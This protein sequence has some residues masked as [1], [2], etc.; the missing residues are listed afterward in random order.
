[1]QGGG[2]GQRCSE[3]LY[4]GRKWPRRGADEGCITETETEDSMGKDQVVQRIIVNLRERKCAW[5][6][7]GKG[8]VGMRQKRV[9]CR[10][11]PYRERV[12]AGIW[13]SSPE[14]QGQKG[15]Q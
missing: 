10:G 8:E 2:A 7:G 6:E 3:S 13:P 9:G 14:P 4:E 12:E 1:M 5:N 15:N 11:G